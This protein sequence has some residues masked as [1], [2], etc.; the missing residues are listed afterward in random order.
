M[1][2][3]MVDITCKKECYR[4]AEAR[5]FIILKPETVTSIREGR[6]P[7][8]DVMTAAQLAAINAVKKTADL[9]LLAHPISIT[10]VDVRL[11]PLEGGVR[12][13]VIVKA[14][15]KTGV[16]LEALTGVVAA[17]L[18]VF[19]M[20]KQLEKDEKGQ[21][22]FTAITDVRVVKKVKSQLSTGETYGLPSCNGMRER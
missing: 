11:E 4:E 10:S 1:G 18:T 5:G 13:T 16:E 20:C 21:Y 15:S 8:G 6:V 7:K 19:D 14:V 22:P 9:I 17:L 2:V 3:E 12:A